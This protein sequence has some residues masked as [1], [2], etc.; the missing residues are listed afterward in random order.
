MILEIEGYCVDL[1]ENGQDAVEK[2][3]TRFYDLAIVDWRLPDI[4]GT[5]LI[6]QLKEIN[7]RMSIIMLTGYPSKENSAMAFRNGA[8]EFILK[9]IDAE[10]LLN[11][12]NELLKK[13]EKSIVSSQEEVKI[14]VPT[15]TI[16]PEQILMIP[17]FLSSLKGELKT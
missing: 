9:P 13:Q 1:A 8:D 2:S 17:L 4:E 6:L 3:K 15:Q 11:K 10:S 14:F 7:P 12:I 16:E 5:T